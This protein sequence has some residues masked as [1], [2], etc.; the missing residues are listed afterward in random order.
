MFW[1]IM[2][3]ANKGAVRLPAMKCVLCARSAVFKAMLLP[4]CGG[5]KE[6]QSGEITIPDFDSSVLK[7]MLY[8]MHTDKLNLSALDDPLLESLFFATNKYQIKGLL[9]ICEDHLKATLNVDNA[10]YRLLLF[11]TLEHEDL[12]TI[13]LNF[14]KNNA[15]E[16]ASHENFAVDFSLSLCKEVIQVLAGVQKK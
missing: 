8:Y 13:A 3:I 1:D 9:L 5:M 15:F 2:I 10:S 14:F 16:C 12:K 4:D 7:V 6:S 11:D